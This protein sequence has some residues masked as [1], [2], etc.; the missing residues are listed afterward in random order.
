MPVRFLASPPNREKSSRIKS[1]PRILG[2]TDRT[3]LILSASF[4]LKVVVRLGFKEKSFSLAKALLKS[5][6][7]SVLSLAKQI[8]PQP[9]IPPSSRVVRLFS[10]RHTG[11]V[12]RLTCQLGV[13]RV[14]LDRTD[15]V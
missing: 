2:S 4:F 1:S 12:D 10:K 9:F 7:F 15:T 5:M 13:I 11:T 8:R 14:A 6:A 3:R